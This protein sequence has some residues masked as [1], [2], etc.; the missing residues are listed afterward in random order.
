MNNEHLER[1]AS[2]MENLPEDALFFVAGQRVTRAVSV[3][4]YRGQMTAPVD[5]SIAIE[6]DRRH[7]EQRRDFY[8]KANGA[9]RGRFGWEQS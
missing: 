5:A 7:L 2:L 4:H 6:G 9:P 1:L 8:E 3:A